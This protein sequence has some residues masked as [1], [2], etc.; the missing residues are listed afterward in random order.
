MHI[1]VKEQI[2]CAG[3]APEQA[4]EERASERGKLLAKENAIKEPELSAKNTADYSQVGNTSL[5]QRKLEQ[6]KKQCRPFDVYTVD[7]KQQHLLSDNPSTLNAFVISYD[8]KGPVKKLNG[9]AKNRINGARILCRHLAYAFAT[10][11][12]GLT[13]NITQGAPKEPGGKF[14]TVASI[15]NIQHNAAVKTDQQL[16]KT[17]V[18]FGI[19][20]AAVYFNAEQ[21]GPA[22]YDMW[23]NKS[24]QAFHGKAVSMLLETENHVMAIKLIPAAESAIRIECYDPKYTTI[25]RRVMVLNEKILQQLTLNQFVSRSDQKAYAIDQGQAGILM[26]TDTVEADNDS[27]A[28]VLA[29]MT[30][31]LLYLLMQRG[32]LNNSYMNSIKMAISE[33]RRDNL[34][35]LKVLLAARCKNGAPG[36]FV[37]LQNGR[38]EA[39]RTYFEVIK[40]HR[41]IIEPNTIMELIAAKRVDG[42]P[43]LF[44]ALQNGRHEA[45]RAYF[46]GIMQLVGIIEPNAIMELIAAKRADG[47]PGLF[48]ALQ[49]GHHEAVRAY[50]EGI[51]QLQALIG[52][53][54]LKKLLTARGEDGTPGLLMALQ[55][56]LPETITAF[57][58]GVKQFADI[59]GPD[60]IKELLA[61]K[62]R[63]GAPGL[64]LAL[65]FGCHE[66]VNAYVEAIKQFRDIIESG[67]I[68][69]L[70]NAKRAN[71]ASG[72][73]MALH[74]GDQGAISAYV[75]GIKLLH[76]LTE[77]DVLKEMLAAKSG[78]GEPI[79]FRMLRDGDQK[80]VSAYLESMKR[81]RDIIEPEVLRELLVAR[82]ANGVPGL[83]AALEN[84]HQEVARVYIEGIEQFAGITGSGV[85]KE[86]LA[87]KVGNGTFGLFLNKLGLRKLSV[88][89][90]RV[91]S[92]VE[93]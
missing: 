60:A 23:M 88:L 50:I 26:S 35:D 17:P 73:L 55:E 11:G 87:T 64:F 89:I 79:L 28:T 13:M 49:N 51:K 40:Q 18:W 14:S 70:L 84:G 68:W 72:L 2:L 66:A 74:E 39:I 8:S 41:H 83:C 43:G 85:I 91:L 78:D 7:S 25:V 6:L 47:E 63:N 21:L 52:P 37:A 65:Q 44:V 30:P 76:D 38:H 3:Y 80:A 27:D 54:A 31:S 71:G 45:I 5:L 22:L 15:I 81:L 10:G 86:L 53:E 92:S 24:G 82:G 69:E 33:V 61:A 19:P 1:G 90:A 16:E 4:T 20:R 67:V 75:E 48:W 29:A 93:T 34:R 56:N 59:I 58:E 36:L 62:R 77:P 32:H 12:F 9:K 46:E 42:V 57:V